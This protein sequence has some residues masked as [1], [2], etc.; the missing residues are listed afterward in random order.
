MS[1]QHMM[2]TLIIRI[3]DGVGGASLGASEARKQT[4]GVLCP[5][6]EQT[7]PN[8]S[9]WSSYLSPTMALKLELHVC[10]WFKITQVK[11]N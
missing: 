5:L 11:P 2:P 3:N 4:V 9:P 7:S 6:P 8:P 1:P 10:A